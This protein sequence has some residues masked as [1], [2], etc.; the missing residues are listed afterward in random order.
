ML[1]AF[2]EMF[3]DC[4]SFA[5][6]ELCD[7]KGN[8]I[9]YVPNSDGSRLVKDKKF[10]GKL[11]IQ[12]ELDKLAANISIGRNMAGVHY[13]SDY[14]DSLRMG[15]RVAVGILMEQA[16]SYG[17]AMQSTFKSFDGDYVTI[18]GEESSCPTLSIIDRNGDPVDPRDWWLRHV[19]G[20]ELSED[21]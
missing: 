13:Y 12:G 15:E 7:S 11:T 5:E 3:D 18:S 20:R 16:P 1:K 2:F 19:I 6:R 21:L 8:S 4:D 9:V 10:E 17:D 14:Y